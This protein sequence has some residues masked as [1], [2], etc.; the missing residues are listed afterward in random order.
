MPT[1]LQRVMIG[2]ELLSAMRLLKTGLRELNRTNDRT[3]FYH[4]PM[5][6]LSS[7]LERLMKVLICCHYLETTGTFPDCSVFS[8]NQRKK[9]THTR[10]HMAAQSNYT[11]LFFQ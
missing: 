11:T 9:K 5:L 10:S 1:T 8:K 3:D 7:G 4:I 6:L 2:E